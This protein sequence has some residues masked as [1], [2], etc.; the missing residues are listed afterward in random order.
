[1]IP[2]CAPCMVQVTLTRAVSLRYIG[3][4][5]RMP[6]DITGATDILN[7]Y[8]LTQESYKAL[9]F[10]CVIVCVMSRGYF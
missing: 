6:G 4:K 8:K 9:N 7:V 10:L 2:I 3:F 1:M 5:Q